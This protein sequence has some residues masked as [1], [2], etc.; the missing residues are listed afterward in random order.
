M[1]TFVIMIIKIT[2]ALIIIISN[3]FMATLMAHES[4][5]ARD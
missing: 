2:I 1:Q 4:S 3:F 5:K